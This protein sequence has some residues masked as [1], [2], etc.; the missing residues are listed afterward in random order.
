M[1]S[2]AVIEAARELLA[3]RNYSSV[4]AVAT[5]ALEDDDSDT[6]MRLLRARAFAALRRDDE[7][8]ADLREC[9]RR[10]TRCALAY[11]L[12]GEICFRR[13][14]YDSAEVFLKEAIRLAP[15]DAHSRDLLTVANGFLQS[16]A[17]VEKLP[18]AAAV[19][20]CPFYSESRV[21][22]RPPRLANGTST[23]A[24]PPRDDDLTAPTQLDAWPV[25]ANGIEPFTDTEAMDSVTL[26]DPP[27]QAAHRQLYVGVTDDFARAEGPATVPERPRARVAHGSAHDGESGEL[28]EVTVREKAK[29]ETFGMYMLRVG[30]LTPNQLH[31]AFDHQRRTNMSLAAAVIALGYATEPTIRTLGLAFRAERGLRRAS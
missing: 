17:A 21:A 26:A 24:T 19:V 13:D 4:V 9:L 14:E 1:M 31:A 29:P 7:A 27:D 23:P 3:A 12:L 25:S 18:A 5:H 6:E 30:T 15:D 10:R 16:T 2:K 22:N 8:Q 20:D 28:G 11:R